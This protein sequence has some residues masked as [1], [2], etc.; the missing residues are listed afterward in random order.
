MLADRPDADRPTCEPIALRPEAAAR[1]LG[2]S[3]RTLVTLTADRD[4]GIPHARLGK[5]VLYPRAAL[6]RWI[7]GRIVKPR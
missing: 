1:A 6:E 2:I 4:S 3:R 7:E 5:C